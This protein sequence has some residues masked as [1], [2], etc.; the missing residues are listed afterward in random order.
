MDGVLS[1]IYNGAAAITNPLAL[2]ALICGLFFWL[3]SKIVGALKSPIE[4]ITG[5]NAFRLLNRVLTYGFVLGLVGL[6]TAA[7]GFLYQTIYENF[8]ERERLTRVGYH[9]LNQRR[10]TDA[11]ETGS[12]LVSG[13]P[14]YFDGHKII[15]S[16]SFMSGDYE[17]AIA[18]FEDALAL[19]DNT[20]GCQ[21]EYLDSVSNLSAALGA[22]GQTSLALERLEGIQSCGFENDQTFN[23]A[24]LYLIERR[25]DE[26]E[27]LILILIESRTP[28]DLRDRAYFM[29]AALG[30]ADS[31]QSEEIV[32]RLIQAHCINPAIRSLFV[33]L[34]SD[35]VSPQGFSQDFAYELEILEPFMEELDLRHFSDQ[36][37]DITNCDGA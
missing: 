14:E 18:H 35:E 21:Q 17:A 16:A 22:S 6:L 28:P 9:Q 10:P 4:K 25:F 37:Q 2:G 29:H 26:A 34:E 32:S 3:S 24:K 8:I 31:E 27:E 20:D 36:I 13:W 33:G 30:V 1:A 11:I 15:G 23:L 19:T 5:E 12:T 7:V